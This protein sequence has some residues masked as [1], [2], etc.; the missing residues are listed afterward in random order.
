M[1]NKIKWSI[2]P[3]HSEIS[4][5]VKHLMITNV[6]GK[7][8]AFEADIYTYDKDFTTAQIEL[9]IDASSISTGY[10]PRD[11]HLK[12][13]DFLN[14]KQHKQITFISSSISKPDDDGNCVL[15]G[16][17][18]MNGIKKHIKLNLQL[19]GIIDNPRGIEKAGFA[20][21][22]KFNRSDWGL[23][24][25]TVLETG[26]ILVSDQVTISCEIELNNVVQKKSV[27]EYEIATNQNDMR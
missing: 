26:G 24:W 13:A 21:T 1:T 6:K 7:F 11:E 19:G 2:D 3:A 25:N 16:E 27:I 18:A 9:R 15:W 10:E 12:S 5:K 17:L 8:K 22:G 20:I 23:T 14:V 4:F